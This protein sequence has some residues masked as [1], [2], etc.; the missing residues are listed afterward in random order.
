MAFTVEITNA[1]KELS[2]R[3]RVD[4][5]DLR[6]ATKLDDA[7]SNGNKLYITPAYYAELSV[8]NDKA[9]PQDYMNFVI[10]SED[11]E[12]FYTGS[13]SFISSFKNIDEEMDGEDYALVIYKLPSKNYSGKEFI[14][15]SL[16]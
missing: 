9:T 10:V 13:Q 5:K 6:N 16:A 12:K 2:K 8:H 3:E 15:C 1:S 11:G 7:L 14:T 4:L